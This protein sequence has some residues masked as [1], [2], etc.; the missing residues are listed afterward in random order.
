[1]SGYFHWL[2]IFLAV[3]SSLDKICTTKNG[4]ACIFPFRYLG[5]SHSS[6]L[7]NRD[8]DYH[9]CATKVDNDLNLLDGTASWGICNPSCPKFSP[10]STKVDTA[11]KEFDSP[12]DVVKFQRKDTAWLS[13]S[14]NL[15]TF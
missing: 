3:D 11:P 4:T 7:P 9:W 15:F 6:C 14:F 8:N 13:K 5:I 2:N 1:M 10:E 12:K